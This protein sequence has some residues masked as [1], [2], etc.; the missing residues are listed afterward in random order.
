M[1]YW[2]EDI[3]IIPFSTKALLVLLMIKSVEQTTDVEFLVSQE[4]D[5]RVVVAMMV[6]LVLVVVVDIDE[7]VIDK[8]YIH[9]QI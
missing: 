9:R 1:S 2:Y 3:S 5:S 6:V 4:Q 8:I 7:E